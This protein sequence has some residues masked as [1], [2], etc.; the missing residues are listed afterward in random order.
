MPR[1]TEGQPKL[2]WFILAVQAEVLGNIR[3]VAGISRAKKL[4]PY[5]R[6]AAICLKW[7]RVRACSREWAVWPFIVGA[8][9][10]CVE[11]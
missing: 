9:A 10:N 3:I 5:L 1:T 6:M 7:V 2:M 8:P 11:P 4:V